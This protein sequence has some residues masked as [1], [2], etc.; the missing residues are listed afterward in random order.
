MKQKSRNL[1]YDVAGFF[2]PRQLENLLQIVDIGHL[3]YGSDYPYTPEFDCFALAVLL[4]KTK[5]LTDKERG[6]IYYDNALKLFPRLNS[7][8]CMT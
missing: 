3:L 2:L 1:Y 6:A 5:L 7:K 4:E 8:V